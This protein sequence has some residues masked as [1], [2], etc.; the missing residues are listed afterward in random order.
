[1]RQNSYILNIENPCSASW[2][3]MTPVDAGKFCA[4]CFKTEIDFSKLSDGE[5]VKIISQNKG[6]V[7]GRF[8][9]EQL[10][11]ELTEAKQ[12]HVNRWFYKYLASVLL[13]GI[14]KNVFSF[15]NNKINLQKEDITIHPIHHEIRNDAEDTLVGEIKGEILDS[16]TNVPI[17][18]VSVQIKDTKRGVITDSAGCFRIKFPQRVSYKDIMLSISH[19]DYIIKEVRNNQIG[20]KIFL[21][22][23]SNLLDEVAVTAY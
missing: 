3:D 22:P 2:K 13:L 7:C 21:M 6:N 5:I 14:Y 9:E 16:I 18:N 12:F 10:N 8:Y 11:K 1:M 15:N 17:E 20:S 4:H 19:V 23:K